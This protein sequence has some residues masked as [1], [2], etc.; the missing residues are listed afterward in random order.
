MT[1]IVQQVKGVKRTHCLIH[2]TT[3]DFFAHLSD[4]LNPAAMAEGVEVE[5]RIKLTWHGW[6]RAATDVVELRKAA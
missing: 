4:F 1:G 5:F 3:E 6:R 2:T